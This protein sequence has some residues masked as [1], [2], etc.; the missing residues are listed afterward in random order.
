MT[1]RVA[2]ALLD[3][4][5]AWLWKPGNMRFVGSHTLHFCF[6]HGGRRTVEWD[7]REVASGLR[8]WNANH[9]G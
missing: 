5:P 4:A 6:G 8:E 3:R 9:N 2:A 7:T 1:T